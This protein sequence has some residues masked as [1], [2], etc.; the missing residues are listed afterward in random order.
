[1]CNHAVK[2]NRIQS[3]INP[4]RSP[5]TTIRNTEWIRR[6]HKDEEAEEANGQTP[7]VFTACVEM[8]VTFSIISVI[9]NEEEE[10]ELKAHQVDQKRERE[11]INE[12]HEEL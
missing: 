5:S 2:L 6:A 7:N 1:M 3:A 9:Q 12:G 4:K 8:E 10:A 11:D